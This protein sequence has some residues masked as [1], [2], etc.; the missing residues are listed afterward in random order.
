[1]EG[2]QEPGHSHYRLRK[3]NDMSQSVALQNLGAHLI[4]GME[5]TLRA[6]W[7]AWNSFALEDADLS[8]VENTPHMPIE[9]TV[10]SMKVA[11][12]DIYDYIPSDRIPTDPGVPMKV[13][14]SEPYFVEFKDAVLPSEG[15][16]PEYT[17]PVEMPHLIKAIISENP[18]AVGYLY[19]AECYVWKGAAKDYVPYHE[20]PEAGPR[21]EALVVLFKPLGET[22]D[23]TGLFPIENHK[24]G[25]R[26]LKDMVLGGPLPTPTD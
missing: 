23:V 12:G 15:R 4:Q 21:Q 25:T 10:V 14:V 18:N 24:D 5:S 9:M 1:M 17:K 16:I 2:W 20:N 26:T 8:Q 6:R 11:D 3:N 7:V 19:T 13:E 22:K